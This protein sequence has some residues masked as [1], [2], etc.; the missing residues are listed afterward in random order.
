MKIYVSKDDRTIENFKTVKL[1]S[2]SE[3][4]SEIINNSCTDIIVD[5]IIDYLPYESINKF[6]QAIV[7]KLRI[8]GKMVITGIDAGELSRDILSG[9]LSPQDYNSII[10]TSSSI[11][12]MSDIISLLHRLSLKVEVATLKGVKYEISAKR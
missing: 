8:D 6:F 10:E 11:S 1:K 2:F 4:L 7:S 9:K 5:N 3:D 12:F